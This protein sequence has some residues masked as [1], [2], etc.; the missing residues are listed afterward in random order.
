MNLLYMKY[1][2]EVAACGSVNKAAEKLYLDQPNLSRAIKDLESSLGVALFERSTRGMKL[3][4]D[5]EIF[6][7]YAKT[8]LAQVDRG[9]SI[10][11]SPDLGPV[12]FLLLFPLFLPV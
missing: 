4:Q 5:G 9:K 2:I 6:L 8:I 11:P 7:K 12:T 3:T 10:F 1:A